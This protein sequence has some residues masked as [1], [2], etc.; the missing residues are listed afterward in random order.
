MMEPK[1]IIQAEIDA[2]RREVRAL[3]AKILQ[4]KEKLPGLEYAL[5]LLERSPAAQPNRRPQEEHAVTNGQSGSS[6]RQVGA[7]ANRW[8]D[9]YRNLVGKDF[10]PQDVVDV[11]FLQQG[12]QIRASDAKRVVESHIEHGYV[13]HDGEGR[14]RVTDV[15]V[16]KF[17]LTAAKPDAP[18]QL[19][20]NEPPEGGSETGEGD[21]SPDLAQA[22]GYSPTPSQA[23]DPAPHSDG[24]GGE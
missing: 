20:E 6:G 9:V 11:I 10:I 18:D 4:V 8:K 23:A 16:E 3:E 13:E 15:A 14:Y 21:A 17:N 12:R 22:P 7:I 24:E 2:I 19:K 1:A 5:S